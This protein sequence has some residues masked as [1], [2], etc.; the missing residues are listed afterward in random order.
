MGPVTCPLFPVLISLG[1]QIAASTSTVLLAAVRTALLWHVEPVDR[2]L[3]M[4]VLPDG[5]HT[6]LRS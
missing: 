2:S 4:T 6:S 1:R 5:M 3:W